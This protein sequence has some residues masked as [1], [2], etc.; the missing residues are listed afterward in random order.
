ML[1]LLN[2][3]KQIHIG[4]REKYEVNKRLSKHFLFFIVNLN[5]LEWLPEDIY[6][7]AVACSD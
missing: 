6:M 7:K 1:F 3:F 4:V 2:I 5:Y